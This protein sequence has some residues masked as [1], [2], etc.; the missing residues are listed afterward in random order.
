M[1]EITPLSP[2]SRHSEANAPV[3]R[4]PWAAFMT[5]RL[6][7]TLHRMV[8]NLKSVIFSAAPCL[9]ARGYKLEAAFRSYAPRRQ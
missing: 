4:T 9:I 1:L 6:K 2:S 3:Y 7:Q 8:G 5:R